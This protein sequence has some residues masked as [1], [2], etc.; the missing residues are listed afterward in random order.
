L[1]GRAVFDAVLR[2]ASVDLRC[3]V[4]AGSRLTAPRRFT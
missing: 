4:F 1:A 3:R 2:F